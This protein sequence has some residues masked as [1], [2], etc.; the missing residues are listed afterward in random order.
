L[1][2]INLA[3][4]LTFRIYGLLPGGVRYPRGSHKV[5]NVAFGVTILA[6][7]ALLAVQHWDSPSLQR[8]TI[9]TRAEQVIQEVV[10]N[11]GE[12]TLIEAS[13][14]FPR[15]SAGDGHTLL[16]IVY[17][18]PSPSSP[19]PL[20]RLRDGLA[21]S[22]RNALSSQEWKIVPVVDVRVLPRQ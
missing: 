7:A 22:I 21:E 15:P 12:A 2:G 8:S 1:T 9:S 4:A 6:L 20:D 5:S 17:V 16:C 11:R 10:R 14:R 19:D 13:A 3:G 18:R